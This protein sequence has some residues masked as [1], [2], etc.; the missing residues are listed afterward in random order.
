MPSA[1]QF[2]LL[3]CTLLLSSCGSQKKIAE[4]DV[5]DLIQRIDLAAIRQNVRD[6]DTYVSDRV[7][8]DIKN[9]KS[10]ESRSLNKTS[11]RELLVQGFAA[12]TNYNID[13]RRVKVTIAPNGQRATLQNQLT[14]TATLKDKKVISVAEETAT[15]EWENNKIVVTSFQSL[16]TDVSVVS[17]SFTLNT[18]QHR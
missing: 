16:V 8:I 18:S 15:I 13:R 3:L 10:G 6:I 14:E 12:V 1:K 4:R 5:H 11:Y 2:G 9:A 17:D 7:Q